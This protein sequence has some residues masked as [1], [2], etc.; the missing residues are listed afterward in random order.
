MSIAA[1]V[2]AMVSAGCTPQQIA[3]AVRAH[4]EASPARSKH[5]EAQARYRARKN[6][7][8]VSRVI[9]CDQHDHVDHREPEQKKGP[10]DPLKENISPKE[11][12][13]KGGQKKGARLPDDWQPSPADRDYGAKLGFS[14]S[15]MDGMAEDLRLWA[16]AAAGPAAI[17]RDWGSA[18]KGWMRREARKRPQNGGKLALV[19]ST[20]ED[21]NAALA[22]SGQRYLPGDHPLF[23]QASEDYRAEHGKYPPR[24]KNGGWYFPESYFAAE[25]AA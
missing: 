21:R 8:A 25:H 19:S 6:D 16:S 9:T 11:K 18:F 15:E 13:P 5:A 17:K 1:I 3:A 23:S 14:I 20:P 4:E 12:P 24:D 7:E 22:K 2:D 10:P